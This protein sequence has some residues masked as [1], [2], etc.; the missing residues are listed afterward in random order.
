VNLPFE[1]FLGL[2]YLR[3]KRQ[4]K[5]IS[6]LTWLSVLGVA[7][8]VMALN[9][10]LSVMN[11]FDD[12]LKSKIVGLNAHIV[13]SGY[14]NRP[15]ADFQKITDTIRT[16]PHVKAVGP[17]IEGQALARSKERS[18]GVMV[19]G[20]DPNAP[21]AIADLNKY[22]WSAKATDLV[23]P[24]SAGAGRSERIFLGAELAQRLQVTVGD[25]LILFLPI[26][27][28]TP[29]GMMPRSLKF[30]V[31]G[32]LSTGMPIVTFLSRTGRRCTSCPRT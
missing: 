1:I 31:V 4:R 27:Q 6:I 13:V 21:Q 32:I 16:L 3:S 20:V 9:V 26:L 28:Q 29:L 17:Y 30:Q 18:L 14:R 12:D 19:W 15:L 23:L 11:G 8:G 5:A 25:D 7:I 24:A 10:V 2:R 22:L